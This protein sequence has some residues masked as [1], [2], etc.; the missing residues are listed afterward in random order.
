MQNAFS[1]SIEVKVTDPPEDVASFKLSA[2]NEVYPFDISLYIKG[3]NVKTEPADG[4][5]VTI[6]LPIPEN[7]VDKRTSLL[8]AHRST[9]LK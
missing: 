2:G 8:V 1:N 4:Y 6:S 9:V 5:A 7:L 3:T